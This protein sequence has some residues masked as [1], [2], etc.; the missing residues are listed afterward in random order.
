MQRLHKEDLSG[1]LLAKG[2]WEHLCLPAIAPERQMICIGGFSY[3]RDGGEPLH[4]A[5]E[6]SVMLERTKR[7]LGSTNFNAQYQQQPIEHAHGLI[8]PEWFARF[9]LNAVKC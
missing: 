8:R 7:E 5:R 1:Y 2:G 3:C 9:N 6:D 4:P